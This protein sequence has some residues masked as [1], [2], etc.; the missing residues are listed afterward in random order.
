MGLPI[1]H[2]IRS[3]D[4][5]PPA[6]HLVCEVLQ[7]GD[8]LGHRHGRPQAATVIVGGHG[9]LQGLFRLLLASDGQLPSSI[10]SSDPSGRRTH[11]GDRTVSTGPLQDRSSPLTRYTR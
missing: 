5:L 9:G 3:D 11:T 10:C 1:S 8:A 4:L 2:M 6:D 7:A